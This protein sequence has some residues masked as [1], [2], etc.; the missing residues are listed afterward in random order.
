MHDHISH[1][2]V[3]GMGWLHKISRVTTRWQKPQ[4]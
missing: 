4:D 2:L 3:C 1:E